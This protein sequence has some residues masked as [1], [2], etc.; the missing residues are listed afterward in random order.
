[1]KRFIQAIYC[2][3]TGENKAKNLPDRVTD[4]VFSALAEAGINRIIGNVYDGREDTRQRTAELCEKYQIQY[5]PSPKTAEEYARILPGKNGEKP[6]TELTEQEKEDLDARFVAEIQKLSEYPAFTGIFLQ[7]EAGYMSFEGIARAK[8]VFDKH[9]KE[10]EFHN[11][12]FSYS[13]N[14]EIFW[15]G[16]N[17]KAP[18]EVPFKLE[19][20]LAITF[21][22]RFN[23]YDKLVEG[24]LTKAPFEFLSQDKYPFENFWPKVPTAVH[25]ALFELNAYFNEKKKKYGSKFYN[26]MQ[27]GEWVDNDVRQMTFAEMALQMHVTAAYGSDGFAYF[28]G[29]FPLDFLN[30]YDKSRIERAGY[31]GCG[32]IDLNGQRTRFCDWLVELNRFFSQ[33]EDDILSSEHLGVASYGTYHNGFEIEKLGDIPSGECVYTGGLSDMLRYESDIQVKCDNEVMVST[34]EKNGKKRYY[35][36][37]LSTVYD[38]VLQV[39]LPQGKYAMRELNEYKQIEP[40]FEMTLKPGCG[41]YIIEE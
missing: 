8:K 18:K 21:E 4:E 23:F 26:Y 13:I 25:V 11:N 39:E 40:I 20:D 33:I 5:F 30:G 35:L 24:L 28:V 14:E 32:L 12:F 19:G 17:G 16:M 3:P 6:F 31:G 37:N 15:G 10:Y 7:D 36:V 1:M 38:N 41:A 29:C 27:V 9:F 22:N 34:F 2:A